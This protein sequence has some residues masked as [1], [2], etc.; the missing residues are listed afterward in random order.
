M[1]V[2]ILAGL[3]PQL[4]YAFEGQHWPLALL[5]QARRQARPGYRFDPVSFGHSRSA[6]KG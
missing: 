2:E 3:L 1:L 4:R 6:G 5:S